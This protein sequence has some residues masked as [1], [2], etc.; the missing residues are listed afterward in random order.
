LGNVY[1]EV[2]NSREGKPLVLVAQQKK[3]LAV[4]K[5]RG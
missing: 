2:V 4:A 5:P 1:W 3:A